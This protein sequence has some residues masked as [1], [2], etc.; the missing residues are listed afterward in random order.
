MTELYRSDLERS[1]REIALDNEAATAALAHQVA[2]L[3]RRGDILALYGDLG[4]GKTTFARALINALP[5]P[6]EEVPSPTFT[7]VQTYRRGDLEIWH[8]DLYR[9]ED[10]EEAYELGIEEAFTEAVSLIE[11]PEKLGA[12]L[13]RDHLALTLSF[14]EEGKRKAI[15]G[16]T[17]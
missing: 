3:L 8:F 17:E 12:L 11:W 9:L 13:P 4:A 1:G 14:T 15:L 16:T 2:Q 6:S 10:P 7:L 5:G